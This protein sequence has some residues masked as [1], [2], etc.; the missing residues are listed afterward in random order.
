M[1]ALSDATDIAE[2]FVSRLGTAC[3]RV[4]IAGSIRRRVLA[5]RDIDLVVLPR[6]AATKTLFGATGS[7]DLLAVRLAELEDR[8]MVDF[9]SNGPRYKRI[10][11]SAS[12]DPIPIDIYLAT[13][14]SWWTTVLIRTGSRLHNIAMA[15]RA[16]ERH[17]VLKSDGSGIFSAGGLPL[18]VRSEEEAFQI[19]GVP[20]KLPEERE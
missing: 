6:Q 16:V 9:Q 18:T 19:L 1:Y 17:L 8:R 4:Q 12:D 13:P 7:Q 5:V 2:E 11:Y 3:E 14:E 20:Y 10:S 15:G